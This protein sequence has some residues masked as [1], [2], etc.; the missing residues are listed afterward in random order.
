MRKL[1]EQVTLSVSEIT[2]IVTNIQTETSH[3]VDSLNEGYNEVKEGT[4]Q[5]EATGR[6]FETINNAVSEMSKKLYL[7]QVI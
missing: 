4:N 7:F 3:V 1:A 2:G 6:S 5:I